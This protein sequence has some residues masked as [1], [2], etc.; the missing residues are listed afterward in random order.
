MLVAASSP[1]LAA[2]RFRSDPA[3]LRA[4]PCRTG[5]GEPSSLSSCNAVAAGDS[6]LAADGAGAL[7]TRLSRDGVDGV[8]VL[9]S[10]GVTGP[11][12]VPEALSGR[13]GV[14][15]SEPAD[16]AAAAPYPLEPRIW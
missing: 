4:V 15:V 14:F 1:A 7:L 12:C 6:V 3:R 2:S 13:G 10:R 16:R 11:V 9:S 5:T 8:A